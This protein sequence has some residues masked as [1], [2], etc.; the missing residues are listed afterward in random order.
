MGSKFVPCPERPTGGAGRGRAAHRPGAGGR[1]DH[2]RRRRRG[3]TTKNCKYLA[4]KDF[5]KS[6]ATS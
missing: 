4:L 3:G 5:K 2:P 6:R 1:A